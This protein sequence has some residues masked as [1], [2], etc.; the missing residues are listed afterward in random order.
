MSPSHISHG[1][2]ERRRCLSI[3][4][5]S[6]NDEDRGQKSQNVKTRLRDAE[7][8]A[9]REKSNVYPAKLANVKTCQLRYPLIAALEEKGGREKRAKSLLKDLGSGRRSIAK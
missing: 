2:I 3:N 4:R 8:Y 1:D 5:V 7:K 6:R 9:I